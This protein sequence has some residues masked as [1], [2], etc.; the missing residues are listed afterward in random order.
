MKKTTTAVAAAVLAGALAVPALADVEVLATIDKTKDIVVVETINVTKTVILFAEVDLELHAAAEAMA[1]ANITNED[2]TVDRATVNV[3]SVNDPITK[4]AEIDDSIGGGT[5]G[6]NTGIV[7]V[8]QDVGNMVNQANL[9]AFGLT[10]DEDAFTDAQAEVDQLNTGNRVLWGLT[11]GPANPISLT[12]SIDHSISGT[13][14][15]GV[16][17]NAG[18]N[19]NQTNALAVAAGIDFGPASNEG[20]VGS[21]PPPPALTG[22]VALAESALGQENSLN[23][24]DEVNATKVASL[25]FSVTNFTGVVGVNQATGNN[26]NQANV[27]SA[28]FTLQ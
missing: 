9:V 10:G 26:S 21:T 27:V 2:N 22:A 14:V 11:P 8:N 7:G 15:A 17:Q 25:T 1:I 16:N 12:A 5:A 24:V 18:N 6:G 13:G 20:P 4:N 28:A 23:V 19:N 3:T